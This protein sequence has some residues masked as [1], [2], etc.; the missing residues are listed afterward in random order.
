MRLVS[1]IQAHSGSPCM[2][3]PDAVTVLVD[4][5]PSQVPG[6]DTTMICT[7]GFSGCVIGHISEV[8]AK[9]LA[10]SKEAA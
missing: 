4:Q 10:A 2:V 9:L 3:R 8:A 5:Q 7:P 1:F 6:K